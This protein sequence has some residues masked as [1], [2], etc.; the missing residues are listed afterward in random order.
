MLGLFQFVV[1]RFSPRVLV[2]GGTPTKGE[3]ILNDLSLS[4][5][6]DRARNDACLYILLIQLNH[7]L[8]QIFLRSCWP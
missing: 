3:N 2:G 4:K 1:F 7:S 8:S 5:I 6:A